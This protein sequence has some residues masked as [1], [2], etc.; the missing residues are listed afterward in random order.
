MALSGLAQLFLELSSRCDK[1]HL[2][3][4]CGHQKPEVN[5]I[6]YGDMDYGLLTSIRAQL[7]PGVVISFHRDGEP[8]AY[9]RLGDA[10]ACFAGFT[11]SL[12]TH[13]LNLVSKAAEIIDRCTTVTISS[14][15]GDPD[16]PAQLDTLKEFLA[17]KGDRAPL[18]QVKLV[19]DWRDH[20]YTL[21]GV[22]V[23]HRAIHNPTGN[24]HYAHLLPTVPE[25][26]LCLDALHRPSIDWEGR[27]YLCNR[28][29]PGRE[30][31]IGHLQ[32][33]TLAQIWHGETRR[34]MIAAH[35]RGKREEANA[36]CATCTYF[37]VPSQWQPTPPSTSQTAWSGELV[38][39]Q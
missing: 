24:H 33:Q 22:R 18:V 26:G 20:P 11:T 9:P 39:I 38:Q 28:L 35:L 37:G 10:L 8:T 25:V 13:G 30:T 6:E 12:V 19:G 32:F 29:A 34:T 14:F 2:C 27:V 23:L 1:R 7:E 16:G 4:F 31:Q 36:T 15:K 3:A 21:P 5:P 17:L